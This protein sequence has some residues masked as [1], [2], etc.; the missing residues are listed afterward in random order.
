M[1]GHEMA[2]VKL[3]LPKSITSTNAKNALNFF[4][5]FAWNH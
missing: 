2:L 4:D 3:T 5:E 1:A